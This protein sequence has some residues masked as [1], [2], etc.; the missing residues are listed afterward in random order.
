L[1][2]GV[3]FAECHAQTPWSARRW[4]FVN[5]GLK[6]RASALWWGNARQVAD[7]LRDARSVG[8]QS[9]P[10]AAAGLDALQTEM[11]GQP[12]RTLLKAHRQACLFKPVPDYCRSFSQWWRQTNVE[13]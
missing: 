13:L 12:N 6:A 11:A 8:W 1:F 5:K 4:S 2:V 3:G 9:E 10:H 7:A